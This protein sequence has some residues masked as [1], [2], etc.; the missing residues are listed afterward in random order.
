MQP[1][2]WDSDSFNANFKCYGRKLPPNLG[3]E[4][5]WD[6]AVQTRPRSVWGLIP[7][8]GTCP[9]TPPHFQARTLA[10]R[11]K[12][13]YRQAVVRSFGATL[14]QQTATVTSGTPLAPVPRHRPTLHLSVQAR[15]LDY[16]QRLYADRQALVTPL[17]YKPPQ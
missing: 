17:P 15:T 2:L 10:V 1:A 11:S 3:G 13:V 7:L 14:A 9:K 6:V 16:D 5:V 12:T 8:P 4:S